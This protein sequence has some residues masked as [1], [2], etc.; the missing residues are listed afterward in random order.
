MCA[1]TGA[2]G[3]DAGTV[4]EEAAEEV[5]IGVCR[6]GMAPLGTVAGGERATGVIVTGVVA[7]D[8][9]DVDDGRSA[10]DAVW[11]AVA[12]AGKALE[13]GGAAAGAGGR[14]AGTSGTTLAGRLRC[15]EW[16]WEWGDSEPSIVACDRRCALSPPTTEPSD[17]DERR[18]SNGTSR[19]FVG[20]AGVAGVAMSVDSTPASIKT[21]SESTWSRLSAQCT[22]KRGGR[23]TKSIV[24]RQLL[25]SLLKKLTCQ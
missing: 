25:C 17:D 21:S 12:A 1:G 7:G 5:G 24:A 4:E 19:V 2:E 8:D 13:P 16:P 14:V 9:D 11:A 18:S 3:L 23:L 10:C 22:F 6:A 15:G 20:V